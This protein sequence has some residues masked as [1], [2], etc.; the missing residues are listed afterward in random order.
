M[1][2]TNLDD[3]WAQDKINTA[4]DKLSNC[5]ATTKQR[6]TVRPFYNISF[7]S[8]LAS[9]QMQC[10]QPVRPQTL[11]ATSLCDNTVISVGAVCANGN[12]FINSSCL[13]ETRL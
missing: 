10:P 5:I 2:L 6:E 1:F 4:Y 9:L 13:K 7:T 3:K 11:W 12:V 8:D